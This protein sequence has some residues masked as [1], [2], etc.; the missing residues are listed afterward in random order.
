MCCGRRAAGHSAARTAAARLRR[1]QLKVKCVLVTLKGK[2]LRG[3]QW[4]SVVLGLQGLG[5]VGRKSSSFL[6]RTLSV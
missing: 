6:R 3:T 5:V 4:Y 2:V 1:R